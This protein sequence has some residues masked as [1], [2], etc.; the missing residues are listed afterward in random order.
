MLMK[1]AFEGVICTAKKNAEAMES[2]EVEATIA[3]L[4]AKA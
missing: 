4:E 3:S 2:E 1:Q